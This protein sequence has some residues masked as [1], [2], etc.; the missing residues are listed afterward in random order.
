LAANRT[1]V[2]PSREY[3]IRI[4]ANVAQGQFAEDALS[5]TLS[6]ESMS[7]AEDRALT[8]ELVYG[9]LRWRRR[10]DGII[11]RL[12]SHPKKKIHETVREILRI[13]LYQA[14][15]L[16][17]I[18]NHAAVDQAVGQARSRFDARTAGFVNA[19][20]RQ[21]IR[22]RD[23]IDRPPVDQPHSLAEYYSHPDWLVKRWL[24]DYG[25]ERTGRILAHNNSRSRVEVRVNRLRITAEEL[26][27]FLADKGVVTEPIPGFPDALAIPSTGGP[28]KLLPGFEAG[29]FTVQATASQLIVPL[30][31]VRQG[32]RVLDACAAT[33]GKTSQLAEVTHN[34]I[35]LTALDLD[36][37]RLEE[38]GRNLDRLG[39]KAVG[40]IA[41]DAE[42]PALIAGLGSFDRILL[43]APCSNLG[44]L[45][46][47]PEAKYRI[48]QKDLK[49]LSQRQLRILT[50]LAPALK[51][52]GTLVYSVC[53]VS[54]EE[55][56]GVVIPFLKQNPEFQADTIE[57]TEVPSAEC[58]DSRG[59]FSTFPP[60]KGYSFDGFFAA[61]ISRRG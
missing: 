9:V 38:T 27:Q 4:L 15:L 45:R 21:A 19:L 6:E 20:L 35:A 52:G 50:S 22:E 1:L 60:S 3:A 17:R 51:R 39:V 12:S 46:H 18:P 53:T 42:D 61:R 25:P 28:V 48:S 54:E 58:L 59:F 56:T 16:D 11:H 7:L 44:V 31:K 47:N 40:L 43:D 13:A 10:L 14:F 55:T 29:L 30:V 24:R 8:T 49:S 41:G 23:R 26:A 33:G 34:E 37:S 32:Q 5:E 36:V 2:S 57:H